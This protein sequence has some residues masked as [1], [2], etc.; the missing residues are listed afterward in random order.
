[1]EQE[2]STSAESGA[3]RPV[4]GRY[5]VTLAGTQGP[6]GFTL[7]ST[8]TA[9][10][11]LVSAAG[12]T[13]VRD[14][15]RQIGVLVIESRT[16]SFASTLQ[17]SPLVDSVG[18]DFGVKMYADA[19]EPSADPLETVQWDMQQIR[20]EEAHAVQ[21]GIPAVDVGVLDSGIDGR[22]PDFTKGLTSNV[23]CT[24]GRDSLAAS[25]KTM[26]LNARRWGN[27]PAGCF[28]AP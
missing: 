6:G 12:G 13:V 11:T 7:D 10:R 18:Q 16:A 25:Q 3:V 9:V 14:L 4:D 27:E 5:L 28:R 21:A 8:M 2:T 24:R 17:A 20:T 19:P 22:H 1:M 23:D 15:S 26:G